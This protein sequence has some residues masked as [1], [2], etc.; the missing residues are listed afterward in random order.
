MESSYQL[1]MICVVNWTKKKLLDCIQKATFTDEG[2]LWENAFNG[3]FFSHFLFFED[4]L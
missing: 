4:A 1:K 2:N 3:T